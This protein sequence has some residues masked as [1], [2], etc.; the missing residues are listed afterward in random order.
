M[1]RPSYVDKTIAS[2]HPAAER[3]HAA[4]LAAGQPGLAEYIAALRSVGIP[5]P[6]GLVVQ[7]GP[8]LSVRH[9]WVN[10]PTLSDLATHEPEQFVVSVDRIL[11]W[12]R[13][14]DGADARIDTN[15]ANFCHTPRGPILVDVLP[16]WRPSLAPPPPRS[17]FEDLFTAL[18]F[19]TE[20][21]LDAVVGYAARTLLASTV[22]HG[23]RRSLAD[24][25][26]AARPDL[27]G[28]SNPPFP[29]GWFW[30]RARLAVAVLRGEQDVCVL[31]E[32]FAATSVLGF[33]ALLED[34]RQRRLPRVTE[35]IT[36]E[37]PR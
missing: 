24:A 13:A 1:T 19:D 7:Q 12:I 31:H 2:A 9:R 17:L 37:V 26:T 3:F 30:A 29:A 20:V 4:A 35:M 33:R 32:F 34:Q 11:G 10:G 14:L 15:L 21:Q 8:G 27:V 18:C 36:R 6:P 23:V 22:P 5:L 25:V 16:P 28:G